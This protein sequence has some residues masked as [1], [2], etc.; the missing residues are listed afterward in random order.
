[1]IGLRFGMLSL[2]IACV[3]VGGPI[4]GYAAMMS[5]SGRYGMTL[6]AVAL[7]CLLAAYT[8]ERTR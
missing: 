7:F 5:R 4:V 8:V 6:L 1:M 2:A 3:C